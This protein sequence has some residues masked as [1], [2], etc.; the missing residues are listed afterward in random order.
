[1]MAMLHPQFR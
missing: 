1:M